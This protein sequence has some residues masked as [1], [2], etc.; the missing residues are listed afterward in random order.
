MTPDIDP[1]IE[2]NKLTK[3]YGKSRGIIDVDL[4]VKRGEVFGFLGPNGAGKSTAIRTILDLIRPTSG[5]ARVNG[6]DPTKEGAKVRR[7]VGYL[8]SDFGTYKSMTA[9]AYLR[10]L[11]EMMDYRGQ[12]RIEELAGRLDL[13]LK[14][15]IKDFSRGNRQ[16]IGVVSAFM[17]N[18]KLAILDE[19]TTGLDP[20]MQQEFYRIVLEEKSK[21]NTVFLSS[22]ILAEVESICDR[23]GI[24][25]EGR[26]I[27]VENMSTFKKK[28]GKVLNVEFDR[29]VDPY[30]FMSLPGVSDIKVGEENILIMTVS[31]HI[32]GVIKELARHTIIDLT[33]DEVS[34]EDLFLKYYGKENVSH[35]RNGARGVVQ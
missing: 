15:R 16:K 7:S 5:W 19:P 17:H 1:V 24:I 22:H 2:L 10:T 9:K 29:K 30:I 8:P 20:L 3:F 28:T 12:D 4:S 27:M 11:L 13:D 25:R 6:M 14:R 21:E 33:Y 34:L 18:P 35:N 31:S 26:L 32:D 23:V